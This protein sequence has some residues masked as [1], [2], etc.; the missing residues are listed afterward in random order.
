M[1]YINLYYFKLSN[2]GIYTGIIQLQR[3]SILCT[4]AVL[5]GF[6]LKNANKRILVI[7]FWLISGL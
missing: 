5:F 2:D 3:I 4:F 6:R 1:W 7:I